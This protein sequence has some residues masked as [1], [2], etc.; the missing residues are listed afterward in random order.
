M[1]GTQVSLLFGFLGAGISF[2]LGVL[3]GSIPPYIGG[4]TDE[5]FSRITEILTMIPRLVLIVIIVAIFGPNL[6]FSILIVG[7]TIWPSTAKIVRSQ[8]LTFKE[9]LF[10]KAAVVSGVSK[11]RILFV[12]LLRNCIFPAIANSTL[13]I[14]TAILTEAGL[15]FLG[16]GDINHVSWGQ[17]IYNG[18]SYLSQAWWLP[19][20]PGLMIFVVVFTFNA[21]GDRINYMFNPSLKTLEAG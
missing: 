4:V 21:V 11:G 8:V 14:S 5:F 20:F 15:S 12:H 17:M 13:Q 7:I 18:Q 6:Y 10:I 19:L 9:R 1:W 16:L 2:V 3:V